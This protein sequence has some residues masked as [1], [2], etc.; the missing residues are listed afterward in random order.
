MSR[1]V[2]CVKLGREAEGVQRRPFR[3]ELGQRIYDQV[4]QEAWQMWLEY[5]TMLINEYRLDLMIPE[6]QKMLRAQCEKFFFSPGGAT[7][8]PPDFVPSPGK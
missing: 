7:P 6:V 1:M 5:S 3:D 8:P 2:K 4:S